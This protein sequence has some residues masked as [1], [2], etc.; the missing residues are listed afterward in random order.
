MLEGS[1]KACGRALETANPIMDYRSL[2]YERYGETQLANSAKL[3]DAAM[4][5][6]QV[7]LMRVLYGRFAPSDKNAVIADLGCGYG[8]IV[9]W[10][11]G[12]GY[13]NACGIDQGADMIEH[14]RALGVKNLSVAGVMDFLSNA[15][16][17][18]DM[19]ILRDVLEHF[20]KREILDVMALCHKA[21]KA[22]GRLVVQVPNGSS[23]FFGHIRYGDFTHETAFTVGSLRQLF[24][25]F[26]FR[27]LSFHDC[28]PVTVGQSRLMT[29]L[30]ALAWAL[31]SRIYKIC[32]KT[33]AGDRDLVVSLCI[34]GVAHR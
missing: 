31:L 12:D 14:A 17:H 19:L 7:Q 34:I 23:P 1:G 16:D 15:D 6:R 11:Q 18:F 21:L 28:P 33:E 20:N 32:L 8:S 3:P 26:R 13:D 25:V 9:H 4:L 30:R 5:S 29:Y 24:S 2:F 10:L 27:N 22:G